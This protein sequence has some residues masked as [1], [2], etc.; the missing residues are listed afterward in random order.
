M[1]VQDWNTSEAFNNSLE[2]E[3]VAEGCLPGGFN[4]LFRK[5]AAAIRVFYNKSYRKDETIFIRV[6]GTTAPAMTENDIY[7]EYTP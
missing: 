5:M 6:L 7:I 4:N 1:P 2:G 3:D